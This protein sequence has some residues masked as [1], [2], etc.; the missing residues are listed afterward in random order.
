M[1]TQIDELSPANMTNMTSTTTFWSKKVT[2]TRAIDNISIK[3]E[4]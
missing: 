4:K 3:K 1:P 2:V